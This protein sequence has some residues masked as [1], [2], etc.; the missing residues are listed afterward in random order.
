M[1]IE[2]IVKENNIDEEKWNISR[3]FEYKERYQEN[4]SDDIIYYDC[5]LL[6]DFGPFKKGYLCNV[7]ISP[8]TY[9]SFTMYVDCDGMGYGGEEFVPVWTHIPKK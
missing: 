5:T 4:P 6:I 2:N 3:I 7:C 9:A 1:E 8:Q